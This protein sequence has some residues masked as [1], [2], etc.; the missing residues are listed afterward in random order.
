M[1]VVGVAVATAHHIFQA[2]GLLTAGVIRPHCA[3]FPPRACRYALQME[4][5]KCQLDPFMTMSH[6]LAQAYIEVRQTACELVFITCSGRPCTW[7]HATPP[8]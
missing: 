7:L 4:L 5:L 2:G 8:C 1:L 3:P 6:W